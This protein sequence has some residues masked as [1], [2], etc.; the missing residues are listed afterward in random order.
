MLYSQLQNIPKVVIVDGPREQA[1]TPTR[2][3]NSFMLC[4]KSKRF[5]DSRGAYG[6]IANA[7]LFSIHD[8]DD[9]QHGFRISMNDGADIVPCEDGPYRPDACNENAR[10]HADREALKGL[11]VMCNAYLE[12]IADQLEICHK[13]PSEAKA[14]RQLLEMARAALAAA[15][16]A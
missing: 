13:Q 12:P 10:L 9:I 6:S 2:V 4:S 16:A 3:F 7:R 14:L 11:A 8:G 15:K 5:L 1:D